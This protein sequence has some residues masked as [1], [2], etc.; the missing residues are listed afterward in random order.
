[1]LHIIQKY[2]TK[3][4]QFVDF[5]VYIPHFRVVAHEINQDL[6]VRKNSEEINLLVPTIARHNLFL[7]PKQTL[8]S[9]DIT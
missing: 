3:Y 6:Q 1:M 5:Y 9:K 2:K 8:V 7:L 4:P